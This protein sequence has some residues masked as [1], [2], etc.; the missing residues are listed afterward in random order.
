MIIIPERELVIITPPRTGSTSLMA[1]VLERYPWSF[2]PYKHM[3]AGGIPFGYKQW[4]TACVVREPLDRLWSVYKYC[5]A[6]V[7]KPGNWSKQ[8]AEAAVIGFEEWLLYNRN[9]FVGNHMAVMPDTL[10][11]RY[12]CMYPMPENVK[13][14][15]VYAGQAEIWHFTDMLSIFAE[16]DL[17]WREVNASKDR[18]PPPWTD[19]IEQHINRYF[20]WDLSVLS[21]QQR[22]AIAR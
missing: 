17:K 22:I 13:S 4:R 8:M 9:V 20:A 14:Q 3:E 21:V 1:S 11:P 7:R 18:S 2:A 19:A 12:H 10:T 5:E 6:Q 16:L 15:E